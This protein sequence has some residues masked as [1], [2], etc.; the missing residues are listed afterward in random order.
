MGYELVECADPVVSA[1]CRKVDQLLEQNC[2]GCDPG[3]SA[4]QTPS[5]SHWGAENGLPGHPTKSV[6]ANRHES[7]TQTASHFFTLAAGNCKVM[8]FVSIP[9]LE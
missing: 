3:P 9:N 5:I 2:W 6:T 8:F 4:E 1:G 7:V